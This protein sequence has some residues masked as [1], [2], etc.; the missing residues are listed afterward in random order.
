M[1]MKEFRTR[2]I[3]LNS[4]T[5]EIIEPVKTISLKQFEKEMKSILRRIKL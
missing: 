5:V 4:H 1:N 3:R 2:K